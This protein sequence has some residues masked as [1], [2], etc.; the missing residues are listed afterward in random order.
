MQQTSR[1]WQLYTEL[2]IRFY[3]L[4]LLFIMLNTEIYS[5]VSNT[6]PTV[7]PKYITLTDKDALSNITRTGLEHH[8]K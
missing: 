3:K 4:S 6:R 1:L 7:I 2:N 5:P 8:R